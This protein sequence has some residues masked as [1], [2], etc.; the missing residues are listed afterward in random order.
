MKFR[1]W[2]EGELAVDQV[3]YGAYAQ[4]NFR[5]VQVRRR[6]WRGHYV[7]REAA[8]EVGGRKVAEASTTRPRWK[9]VPGSMEL[10]FGALDRMIDSVLAAARK[11]EVDGRKAGIARDRGSERAPRA[12]DDAEK[13]LTGRGAHVV[14]AAEWPAVKE[15][16]ARAQAA[17]D[18][19]ADRWCTEEGYEELHEELKEQLGEDYEQAK[20]HIPT[21][22]SLRAKFGMQFSPLKIGLVA[23]ADDDAQDREGL[24]LQV[25]EIL[26]EAVRTPREGAAAV[27]ELLAMQLTVPGPGGG[28]EALRHTRKDAKT[29]QDVKI[30]RSVRAETVLEAR[31]AADERLLSDPALEEA[32][33]ALRRELPADEAAAKAAAKT[34]NTDDD[35]ALRVAKLLLAAALAARDEDGMC[36]ALAAHVKTPDN[37]QETNPPGAAKRRAGGEGD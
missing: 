22:E 26:E 27:F 32:R 23:A 37:R 13:F 31:R 36:A 18:S 8:V 10:Q 9:L 6:R 29:G 3:G 28:L 15:T 33:A 2:L 5:L 24:R 30:G 7:M 25:A 34:L 21:R 35:A 1:E 14:P 20:G 11:R 16:L 12:E 4:D 17:W 19:A